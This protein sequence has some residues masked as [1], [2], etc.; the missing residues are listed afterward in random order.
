[1]SDEVAQWIRP[2]TWSLVDKRAGERI[3]GTLTQTTKHNL[4]R[5]IAASLKADRIERARKVGESLMGHIHAGDMREAWR[6]VQGWYKEAGAQ[7]AK[8]CHESMEKQT[9]ERE[10]LYAR[11]PP[12]GGPNSLQCSKDANH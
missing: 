4:N 6:S 9:V 10:E 12:P 2:S 3:A 7:Q 5:E 1:M 8:K 11:I